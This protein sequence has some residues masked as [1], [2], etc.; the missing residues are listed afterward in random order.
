MTF[1]TYIGTGHVLD[2]NV[3]AAALIIFNMMQGPLI[4]VPFFF[5]EIINLIVSMKRIEGFLDLEEV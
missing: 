2:F 5:S 3:A 4:Q 1:S